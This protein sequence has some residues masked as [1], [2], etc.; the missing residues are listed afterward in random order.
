[1]DQIDEACEKALNSGNAAE[2]NQ[3]VSNLSLYFHN[4]INK[5]FP[6]HL[7]QVLQRCASVLESSVRPFSI[8]WVGGY[9]K[10]LLTTRYTL[11]SSDDLLKLSK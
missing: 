1:M 9:L 5:D 7:P 3:A 11:I 2:R 8:M 4:P 10:R 6:N